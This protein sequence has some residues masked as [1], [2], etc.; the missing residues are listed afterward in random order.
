MSTP[1]QLVDDFSHG[2][3]LLSSL[4]TCRKLLY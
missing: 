4:L 1:A 3:G 2:K